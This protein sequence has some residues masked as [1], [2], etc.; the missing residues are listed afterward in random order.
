M[1]CGK[2]AYRARS[3]CQIKGCI[4]LHLKVE[5]E[6]EQRLGRQGAISNLSNKSAISREILLTNICIDAEMEY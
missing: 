5:Q 1:A 6:A 4:G 3:R 2:A